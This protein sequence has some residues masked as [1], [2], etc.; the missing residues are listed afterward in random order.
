[1]KI[2]VIGGTGLYEME[3][4]DVVKEHDVDTAFGK[5]SSKIIETVMG[6]RSVFFLPR[7]GPGHRFSPSEINYRANILALKQLGVDEV[8]SVSAVGSL[9]ESIEP[10][11]VVMVDQFFD[12]TLGRPRTFFEEGIVAHVSFA[13][14][15]CKR[16]SENLARAA[17]EVGATVHHG[18]TYV[19]IE[20]PQF[21]TRAESQVFRSFDMDVIGMTNLPEA[22]L[23][24]EAEMC[25]ATMAMVTDYDCWHETEEDVSVEA[26]I[27][28][29]KKNVELAGRII[30]TAVP[31]RE[32]GVNC[33]CKRALEN[34]IIT[35]RDRIP[36]R[37]KEMLRPLVDRYLEA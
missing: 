30:S 20:G 15:V 17:E 27:K 37:V 1:M 16:L 18:G 35:A 26:V 6:G 31:A 34:A 11:H 3:G 29:L 32:E 13:D 22:R 5:P 9:K 2:G 21:S 14:P 33:Q 10:G 25:Y 7:H 36:G 23:A 19:C 28:V 4:I 12:R 8:I 24:R